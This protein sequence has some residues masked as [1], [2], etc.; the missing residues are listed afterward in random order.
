METALQT[1]PTYVR[2]SGGEPISS[3]L[4][5]EEEVRSECIRYAKEPRWA[6]ENPLLQLSPAL[7]VIQHY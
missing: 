6:T 2:A 4:F 3:Q 7:S 5:K 1:E